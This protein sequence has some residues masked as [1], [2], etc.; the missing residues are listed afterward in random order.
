M[1]TWVKKGEEYR[2]SY[3]VLIHD[4]PAEEPLNHDAAYAAMKKY[5]D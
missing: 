3:A 2:L 5:F 4:L 1:K